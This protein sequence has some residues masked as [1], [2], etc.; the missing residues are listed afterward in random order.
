VVETQS[1]C[2]EI[3]AE[4]ALCIETLEHA[5]LAQFPAQTQVLRWAIVGK[6]ESTV[7]AS[8]SIFYQIEATIQRKKA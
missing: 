3:P 8:T 1:L 2:I 7:L 5:I 6:C 4:K